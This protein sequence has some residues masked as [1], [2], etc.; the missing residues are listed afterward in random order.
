MKRDKELVGGGGGGGEF[1][2][3]ESVHV[4]AA[5]VQKRLRP[6]GT[7]WSIYTGELPVY[8]WREGWVSLLLGW[9]GGGG[10]VGRVE[11]A[12]R[13]MPRP[14]KVFKP[15]HPALITGFS[16]L[17]SLFAM[18]KRSVFG[19]PIYPAI[20]SVFVAGKLYLRFLICEKGECH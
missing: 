6:E 16:Q 3:H 20:S 5:P 8:R 7:G 19:W 11:K 17:F 1:T 13:T 14:K 15:T 2:Y 9:D 4:S 18:I 12:Y 10:G